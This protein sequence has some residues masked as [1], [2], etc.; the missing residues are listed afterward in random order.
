MNFSVAVIDI[1]SNSVRLMLKGENVKRKYLITTR[2]AEGKANNRLAQ[3]SIDRTV[4]AVIIFFK[5]AIELNC[6]NIYA[7]ATAAVRSS[8]NGNEFIDLVKQKTGLTVDVIS[9]ELEA[10]IA[11]LGA[12]NGCDGGVID[13]GGASTEIAVKQGKETVYSVSYP[14]GA[15]SLNNK[16]N[17]DAS[18]AINYLSNLI[19]G[20][21]RNFNC[22]FFGI[23]GTITTIGSIALDL[24]DYKPEIF[25]GTT[26]SYDCIK[27]KVDLLL[28]L[29]P[30]QIKAQFTV[31][32]AR[33][34]IIGLGGL[35]LLSVMKA[36][37][38][39]EI[40]VSDSDNLEGYLE[41]ILNEKKD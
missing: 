20:V 17:G 31:A 40:T 3:N 30:E 6:K 13:I 5:K 29:T 11:L 12:L 36:Y 14:I 35:I 19:K 27:Q 28:S 15:V 34:D 10:Q 9:G 8:I 16:F 21:R 32:S 41:Y 4:N 24:N 25:S 33:A 38:I 2:L 1:G 39:N 22:K 23:G 26:I 18:G 7:F 37:G